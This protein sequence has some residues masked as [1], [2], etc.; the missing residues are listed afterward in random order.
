MI[1][2]YSALFATSKEIARTTSLWSPDSVIRLSIVVY[3]SKLSSKIKGILMCRGLIQMEIPLY[4]VSDEHTRN[5]P[6]TTTCDTIYIAVNYWVDL[7]GSVKIASCNFPYMCTSTW[8]KKVKLPCLPSR[9]EFEGIHWPQAL[10]NT[11]KGSTMI[12]K[13]R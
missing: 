2:Q 13:F 7:R 10:K 11:N 1:A 9:G 4:Y 5:V 12:L 3:F 8:I 6:W